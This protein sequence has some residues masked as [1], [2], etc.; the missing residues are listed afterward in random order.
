MAQ[1]YKQKTK[2]IER[3]TEGRTGLGQYSALFKKT[4]HKSRGLNPPLEDTHS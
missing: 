1:F 4:T 3:N 2:I